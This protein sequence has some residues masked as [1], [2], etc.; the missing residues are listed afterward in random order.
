[1]SPV[2]G[3]SRAQVGT[4]TSPSGL[5]P[6]KHENAEST[7]PGQISVA[8][9]TN[10]H[11]CLMCLPLSPKSSVIKGLCSRQVSR[12]YCKP[13]LTRLHGSDLHIT[14]VKVGGYQLKCVPQ[15]HMLKL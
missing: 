3:R 13:I 15:I 12:F 2:W 11:Y 8:H 14:I 4:C 1:M 10:A 5:C 6:Y 7:T 9:L